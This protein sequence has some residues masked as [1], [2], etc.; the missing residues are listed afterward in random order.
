MNT[1]TIAVSLGGI[2]QIPLGQGRCFILRGDEI[3]IFRQRDGSLFATENLCP[4][5]KGPLS[6]G[7]IGAGKVVCPLHGHKFDL[8][9]GEGSEPHECLK[10]FKAWND[11]GQIMLEY[12]LEIA[13]AETHQDQY[14]EIILNAY[15][16]IYYRKETA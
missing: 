13:E 4:H 8:A 14:A 11:N 16:K 3:A 5:R 6:E 10:V 1:K 7:V 2:E 15:S 12:D 9:T